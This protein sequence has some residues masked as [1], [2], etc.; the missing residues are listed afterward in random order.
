MLEWSYRCHCSWHEK[1]TGRRGH[2]DQVN[3]VSILACTEREAPRASASKQQ[4]AAAFGSRHVS[5]DPMRAG[6]SG[7]GVC[8]F[9]PSP[10]LPPQAGDSSK[11]RGYLSG[12]AWA[13]PTGGGGRAGAPAPRAV[14]A[15]RAR[16]RG[17]GRGGPPVAVSA[18]AREHAVRPKANATVSR[19]F[20]P[21]R[22]PPTG[23]N[24]RNALGRVVVSWMRRDETREE[25]GPAKLCR[26]PSFRCRGQELLGAWDRNKPFV[27]LL[28]S[29]TRAWL[30]SHVGVA[31]PPPARKS[32]GNAFIFSFSFCLSFRISCCCPVCL[33]F[34]GFHTVPAWKFDWNLILFRIYNIQVLPS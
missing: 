27:F 30:I 2:V 33:F 11:R 34:S 21:G 24:D 17:R 8:P 20:P 10:S 4:Q 25:G 29:S 1:P 15:W 18:L 32:C 12:V 26:R 31:G 6:R 3:L 16:C 7:R 13:C 28:P 9:W 19:Q 22:P 5:D 23:R 14:V